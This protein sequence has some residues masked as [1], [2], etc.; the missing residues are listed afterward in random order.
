VCPNR[1]SRHESDHR[2]PSSARGTL[3]GYVT[4]VQISG[5]DADRGGRPRSGR[6]PAA[7][8]GHRCLPA[9][10]VRELR[11]RTDAR[12][13]AP[14]AAP[15]AGA[16]AARCGRGASIS[17]SSCRH[18]RRRDPLSPASPV[19][20]DP[21]VGSGAELGAAGTATDAREA[22]RSRRSGVWCSSPVRGARDQGR[23]MRKPFSSTKCSAR[24]VSL[25]AMTW[26]LRASGKTLGQSLKG[27]LVVMQVARR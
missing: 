20:R 19:P 23:A 4:E 14:R 26:A 16:V 8:G 6:A 7:P 21:P 1:A 25:S 17:G 2:T 10:V 15:A 27:R 12:A 11:P 18:R 24:S 3:P 5:W 9:R 22:K 13:H